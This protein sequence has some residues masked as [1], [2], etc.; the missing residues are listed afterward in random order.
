MV[1][2][3]RDFYLKSAEKTAQNIL[4]KYIVRKDGNKL[5]KGKIIETEAYVGPQ[6]R[7]SHAFGNKITKRNQVEYLQG[8]YI[9]IYLVYGMYWQLN[10]T[11]G[12]KGYPECFLIRAI[13]SGEDIKKTN[14]PGKLCQWLKL[15]KSFYGEDIVKSKKIWTENCR[16]EIKKFDIISSSRIGIDYAGS[17]WAK[18]KLRFFLKDY[19]DYLK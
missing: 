19:K 4:G 14:G 8:G 6:D 11:T 15:D 7:A 13:D 18:R 3:K 10:I 12:A 16:Q 5:L 1:R 2:I 9:Y 17:Y